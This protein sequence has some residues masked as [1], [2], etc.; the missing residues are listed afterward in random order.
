MQTSV[1]PMYRLLV[2]RPKILVLAISNIIK[3]I[4]LVT[5]ILHFYWKIG[6]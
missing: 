4:L 5:N 6:H 3:C 1:A 2:Y